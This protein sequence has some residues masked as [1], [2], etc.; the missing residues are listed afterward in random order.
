[1][2]KSAD[3][4]FVGTVKSAEQNGSN[5]R[6][7][8]QV[9]D[10]WKGGGASVL[11]VVSSGGCKVSFEI[12]KDYLVYAKKDDKGQFVTDVC[13]GTGQV[14]LSKKEIKYL[15]HPKSKSS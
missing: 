9:S 2:K 3:A 7:V 6:A 5:T 1:M 11:T 12:E 8:L 15:G 10:S 14:M 4:I 13:M